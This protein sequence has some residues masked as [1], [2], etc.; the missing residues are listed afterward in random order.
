M[1]KKGR[2]LVVSLGDNQPEEFTDLIDKANLNA[3]ISVVTEEDDLS[4]V[5]ESIKSIGEEAADVGLLV[6]VIGD[7][8]DYLPKIFEKLSEILDECKAPIVY[9]LT[10]GDKKKMEFFEGQL[11]EALEVDGWK[12]L[13]KKDEVDLIMCGQEDDVDFKEV[14]G[15]IAKKIGVQEEEP[16]KPEEKPKEE[17]KKEEKKEEKSEKKVEK[18]V[19]YTCAKNGHF[20][21]YDKKNTTC[22]ECKN[23]KKCRKLKRAGKED[24]PEEPEEPADTGK[25]MEKLSEKKESEKPVDKPS[26]ERD[27]KTVDHVKA[28]IEET[29]KRIEEARTKSP[30]DRV[31][32]ITHAGQSS[33]NDISV[34]ELLDAMDK[35]LDAL[36]K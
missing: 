1:A 26:K 16:E 34:S 5:D 10:E 17:T 13:A 2:S 8:Y 14:V 9:L 12:E 15:N 29:K 32:K 25:K 4:D 22:R 19:E 31:V 23:R 28:K 33:S 36:L 7:D 35:I 21:D 20:G 30:K 3:L 27:D 11:S 18:E 24:E 6:V